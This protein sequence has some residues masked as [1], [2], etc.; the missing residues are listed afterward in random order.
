MRK[1]EWD[2][3]FSRAKNKKVHSIYIVEAV[4]R[5]SSNWSENSFPIPNPNQQQK[6]KSQGE[7]Q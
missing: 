6:K 5:V 3:L 7:K 2:W 1:G 4:K